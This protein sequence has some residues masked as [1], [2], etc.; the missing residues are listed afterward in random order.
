L[1]M[2]MI[3]GESTQKW[4]TYAPLERDYVDQVT[5]QERVDGV[6]KFRKGC[7]QDH[8]WDCEN[9]MLVLARMVGRYQNEFLTTEMGSG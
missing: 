2:Q 7:S 4:R 6:W 3:R 1:L 5:A 8:L 9:M